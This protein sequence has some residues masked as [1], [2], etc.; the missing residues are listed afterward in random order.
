M[1]E[2][3]MTHE[4]VGNLHMH[5]PY[6]D[7]SWYHAEIARAASQAGLDFIVVTDHN[8]WVRGP[9]GY[10]HNV[11][12]LVGQEVHHT[13]RQPQV[14]HLLVYN[15]EAELSQCAANPQQL[16]DAARARGG[17]TFIA[18]PF[19]Y[20]LK[21][22]REPGI[23]WVDWKVQGYVGLE[24]WNYMSE[25]KARLPHR[26]GAIYYTL[27]PQR[28]IRGPF[29]ATLKLWD[30]LLAG[31]AKVVGFGNA[32]AHAFN[33]NMGPIKRVVFP[34]EYTF[35]C[36]NT[37]LLIDEPL[38]SDVEYDK[39]LIYSA[40]ERG[41]GWVGYDL[42]GSTKGFSF[43]ARSASE[44]ATLGEELRRA[45]AVNFDVE[46]PQPATIQIVR[47]G[48]GVVARAKGVKIKFTSVEA[49]AYR[50]EAYRS[51]KGWIFS[52]PIYVL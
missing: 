8:V 18:H 30:D 34:Y 12:V 4:V 26:L 3:T 43:K 25:Y 41:S 29:T 24:I 38:T 49:G 20:P 31:G 9:Q 45:G 37:H 44:H 48:K 47:A 17:L 21:F 11:L 19:D 42:M 32:D 52:N 10:H 6:S 1:L 5:T 16:I 22:M 15:A 46:V 35:R 13:Q 33:L 50:V 36:V 40:L 23:P 2:E 28:A 39:Y 27:Y 51:G 7:G 14:N